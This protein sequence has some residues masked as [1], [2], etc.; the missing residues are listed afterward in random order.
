M[1]FVVGACLQTVAMRDEQ[2]SITYIVVL[3]I[4][5]ITALS[6]S[7]VLLKETA[8]VAKLAGVG[9][10]LVGIVLLRANKP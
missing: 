7:V 6:L 8:S 3:G 5:A 10:V 1:F 4:E 2:M 9:F